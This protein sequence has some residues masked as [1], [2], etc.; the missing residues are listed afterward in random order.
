MSRPHICFVQA[1]ALRWQEDRFPGVREG[2]QCKVLS[3]DSVT[4][5]CTTIV[6]YPPGWRRSVSE[7]LAAEEEFLILDGS[8][9]VNGVSYSR[10]G[11]GCLPA[12]SARQHMSSEGG[13]VVLTMFSS[14]PILAGAGVRTNDASDGSIEIPDTFA[15]PWLTGEDGS[16]TGKPLNHGLATKKLRLDSETGEQSFLY[17]SW[18]QH[19]PPPIMVG[20]FGHPVVE[21]IFVLDGEFVFGD[22]GRMGPGAYC[23]WRE[24]HDHGPV[25]SIPG[26]HL[27]IRVHGGELVNEFSKEPQR[28]SWT[29]VHRPKLP[30]DLRSSGDPFVFP[31]K[32]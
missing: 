19:P 18:P 22:V 14:S 8:L 20:G 30:P 25:G 3:E 32:W 29:P 16:V 4:G 1:Q 10:H 31:D 28:F 17:C 15:L 21:E 13:A 23:W 7:H 2:V 5:A 12:L 26:Y 24:G 27:F 9:E 11:Y 6:K